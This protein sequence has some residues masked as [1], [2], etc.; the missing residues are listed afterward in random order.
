[1]KKE[2]DGAS[3]GIWKAKSLAKRY[4]DKNELVLIVMAEVEE[5]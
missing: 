4:K 1:M 2:A 5:F 3:E